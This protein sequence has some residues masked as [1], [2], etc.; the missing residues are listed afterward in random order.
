MSRPGLFDAHFHVIDPRF[1]L[2]PSQ[3]WVPE[4][5]TVDDWR[6]R[7]AGLGV[8]GGAV[9]SG[10]FHGFDQAYLLDALGRLGAGFV[11][12]TQLPASAPDELV[13]ALDAAG[14]RA[15]RFNLRRGGSEGPARLEGLAR[16]LF[17]L[18]GWHVELYADGRDL[19]ELEGILAGL[20]R[21]VVDHLGLTAD[22]LGTLL[23]L[24]ERGARVKASGF[25][26]VDMDVATALRRIDATDPSA[27]MFGTDLPSTRAARPFADRDV[28]FVL[29]AL[30]QPAADRVL[31]DNA[32]ALYRPPT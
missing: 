21:V 24:V 17:D 7:T 23:R 29:D 13:R 20:P 16:R 4:P 32:V 26:R 11:G 19:V 14:V 31:H 5:F 1:E 15:V 12:V 25:G 8:T 28:E 27:L 22:G 30:G 9:V 10:S 3:G 2:V 6:A 18:T